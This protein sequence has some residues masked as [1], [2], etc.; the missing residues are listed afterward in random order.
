MACLRGVAGAEP[1]P[2]ADLDDVD[3]PGPDVAPT[4]NHQLGADWPVAGVTPAWWAKPDAFAAL[5][6]YKSD[7]GWLDHPELTST[8][9]LAF[10]AE[11]RRF[12]HWTYDGS[13]PYAAHYAA[14]PQDCPAAAPI[15]DFTPLVWFAKVRL[16]QG[17]HEGDLAPAMADV[18]HLAMLLAST[19]TLVGTLIGVALLGIEDAAVERALADGKV[20][21]VPPRPWTEDD[22]KALKAAIFA[23]SGVFVS[24]PDPALAETLARRA[25][26]LPGVCAGIFEGAMR[27]LILRDA[28]AH[29]W[30]GEVDYSGLATTLDR[31]LADSGCAIPLARAQWA[32]PPLPAACTGGEPR[33]A[34][35]IAFRLPYARSPVIAMLH[36]LASDAALGPYGR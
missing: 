12:D 5:T 1:L 35:S 21:S 28:V 26:E 33:D 14:H 36:G 6:P 9:D 24:Q 31:A 11:W 4:L 7:G 16:A 25:S 22:R 29:P 8:Y 23:V 18:E 27:G 17:Y 20:A 19:D 30:P 15:P 32:R 13:D 2:Q 34:A 3:R 10:L